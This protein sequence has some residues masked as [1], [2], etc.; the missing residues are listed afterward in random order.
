MSFAMEQSINTPDTSV[1]VAS[2]G[3][4]KFT[5]STWYARKK[6]QITE[7]KGHPVTQPQFKRVER[8]TSDEKNDAVQDNGCLL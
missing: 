8:G 1:K 7:N 4:A 6:E 2:A 3:D 5:G